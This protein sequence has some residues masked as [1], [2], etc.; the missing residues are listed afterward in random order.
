MFSVCNQSGVRGVR[1]RVDRGAGLA[2]RGFTLIELLMAMGIAF[3]VL[4]GLAFGYMQAYRINDSAMLQS[5]ADR[6]VVD[7]IAMV[8]AAEWRYYGSQPTNRMF[9]FT[10]VIATNLVVPSVSSIHVG[11]RLLTEVTM[12][13]SNLPLAKLRVACVWT[14]PNG[15]SYTNEMVTLRAPN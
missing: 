15:F 9:E 6:L 2:L 12:L 14:G 7:R 1:L 8:R 3:T 4:A 5:A 10:N 11:A 13:E